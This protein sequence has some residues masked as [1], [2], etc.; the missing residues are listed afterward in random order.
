MKL[1]IMELEVKIGEKQLARQNILLNKQKVLFEQAKNVERLK[2][3]DL[4]V[5]QIDEQIAE[6]EL[7]LK[8][9]KNGGLK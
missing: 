7:T 8:E 6:H 4:S 2:D 3:F 9:L 5:A 1:K